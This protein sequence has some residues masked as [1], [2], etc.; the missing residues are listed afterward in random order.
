MTCRPPEVLVIVRPPP[1]KQ[2]HPLNLQI[3]LV[4]P[5]ANTKSAASRRSTESCRPGDGR[6]SPSSSTAGSFDAVASASIAGASDL[7]NGV[8]LRRTPSATSSRSIASTRSNRSWSASSTA[9]SAYASGSRKVLPLYNL[10][11]HAV[12]PTVISDAGTDQKLAKLLKKG[13]EIFDFGILEPVQLS[14]SMSRHNTLSPIPSRS[15]PREHDHASPSFLSKF[16]KISLKGQVGTKPQNGE[17]TLASN[18][19]AVVPLFRTPSE[20]QTRSTRPGQGYAFTV[21][22]WMRNDIEGKQGQAL[23]SAVRFEWRRTSEKRIRKRPNAL[24]HPAGP[25]SLCGSADDNPSTVIARSPARRKEGILA[26]EHAISDPNN[27]V[28]RSASLSTSDSIP[29]GLVFAAAAQTHSLAAT[30]NSTQDVV[31]DDGDDDDGNES[32][33]EDSERPY[34]CHFV[35]SEH[36]VLLGTLTPAPHHP[37]L[38]GTL[39][40]PSTL[41]HV[42]VHGVDITVEELKDVLSITALWVVVRENL[43]GL[44]DRPRKGQGTGGLRL[45]GHH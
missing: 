3:Q 31:N 9:S 14:T 21:R 26:G 32:D 24:A 19:L 43:G 35:T 20:E 41:S 18:G 4:N 30:T 12:M 38:V 6:S 37:K 27:L 44:R 5:Q 13:L 45:G 34:T 17:P 23:A 10:N 22:K 2:N 42:R 25:T 15:H 39:T 8:P 11:F 33:P 28:T 40:V 29:S 36:K 1:S 7:V 16:K